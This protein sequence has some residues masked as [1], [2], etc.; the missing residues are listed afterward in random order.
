[1]YIKIEQCMANLTLCINSLIWPKSARNTILF[2]LF[3][4]SLG[5]ILNKKQVPAF[6]LYCVR[7][8][9][10]IVLSCIHTTHVLGHCV[11]TL[12]QQI[13]CYL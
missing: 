2:R 12:L 8:N 3:L 4:F 10:I 13:A 1:M 9:Y 6:V 5:N 11:S 7:K